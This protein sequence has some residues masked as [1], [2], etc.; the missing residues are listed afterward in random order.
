MQNC[1]WNRTQTDTSGVS[2]YDTVYCG[3]KYTLQREGDYRGRPKWFLAWNDPKVGTPLTKPF[4]TK[5]EATAYII[6]RGGR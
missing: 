5:R 1:D 3:V 2:V 4:D 6:K